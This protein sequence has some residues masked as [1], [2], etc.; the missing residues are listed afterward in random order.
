MRWPR[1]SHFCC[2]PSPSYGILALIYKIFMQ[3]SR[4]MSEGNAQ[5][6]SPLP[7]APGE[8]VQIDEQQ[9]KRIQKYM[10]AVASTLI[11]LLFIGTLIGVPAILL[12]ITPTVSGIIASPWLTLQP[13]PGWYP[14][15]ILVLYLLGAAII[16]VFL[17]PFSLFSGHILPQRYNVSTH[18][19]T[20]SAWMKRWARIN[21]RRLLVWLFML[22][23]C[24]LYI[25][26]QPEF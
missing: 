13:E 24:V 10:R 9:Q 18:T 5:A 25:A 23:C 1:P 15:R 8:Q 16:G 4:I 7:T 19:R 2:T 21:G 17:F 11:V 20:F 3:E 12:V 14:L 26:V 22:E 6:T